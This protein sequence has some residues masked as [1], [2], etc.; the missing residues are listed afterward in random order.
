MCRLPGI[1]KTERQGER[2]AD[3]GHHQGC[4]AGGAGVRGGGVPRAEQG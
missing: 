4:G 2:G 1:M 3:D